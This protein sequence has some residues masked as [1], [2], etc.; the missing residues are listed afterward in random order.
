MAATTDVGKRLTDCVT[1]RTGRIRMTHRVEKMM[2]KYTG[3]Q[4]QVKRS[5]N[6]AENIRRIR[7][8]PMI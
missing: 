5:V 3:G 7:L 1:G 4:G 6:L 8:Q 2:A